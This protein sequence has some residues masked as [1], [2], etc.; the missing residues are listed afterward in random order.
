MKTVEKLN[1]LLVKE[2]KETKN[3]KRII[4]EALDWA[5]TNGYQI[6]RGGCCVRWGEYGAIGCNALGAVLL[7]VGSANLVGPMGFDPCWLDCLSTILGTNANWISRFVHG[8][9]YGNELSFSFQ[10]NLSDKEEVIKEKVS[11]YG[12]KLARKYFKGN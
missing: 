9:D 7:R 6:V 12:A 2:E 8:F 4:E 11:T 5:V 10:E 3:T 1:S